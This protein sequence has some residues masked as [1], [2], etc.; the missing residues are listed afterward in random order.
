[1]PTAAGDAFGARKAWKDREGIDSS[2][3]DGRSNSER[4]EFRCENNRRSAIAVGGTIAVTKRFIWSLERATRI[5][6]A[7]LAWEAGAHT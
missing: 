3:L 1:M 7:F 6:L 5:E 2:A 4:A